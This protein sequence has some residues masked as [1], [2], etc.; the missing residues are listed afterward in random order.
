MGKGKGKFSARVA[1]FKKGEILLEAAYVDMGV[2][3]NYYKAIVKTL[4]VRVKK[5]YKSK[6][7]LEGQRS[8]FAS[9]KNFKRHF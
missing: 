1:I 6:L 8:A 9:I 3:D 2:F 4:P 7:F 5:V